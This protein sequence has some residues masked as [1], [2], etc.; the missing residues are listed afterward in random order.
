MFPQR[1]LTQGVALGSLRDLESFAYPTAKKTERNY[2]DDNKKT[3]YKIS[4]ST[5]APKN[6]IEIDMDSLYKEGE[7]EGTSYFQLNPI[8]KLQLKER[9]SNRQTISSHYNGTG[10][11][12]LNNRIS[13]LVSNFY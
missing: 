10:E 1:N 7:R 13:S 5:F 9:F 3:I 12:D 8:V 11:I 6:Q 4:L 2:E